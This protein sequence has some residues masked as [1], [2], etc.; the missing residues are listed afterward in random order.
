[1]ETNIKSETDET[2]QKIH[3]K[4]NKNFKVKRRGNLHQEINQD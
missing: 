3:W 2:P 4:H 1:M